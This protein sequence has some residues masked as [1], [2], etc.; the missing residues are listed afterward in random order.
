VYP[1]PAEWPNANLNTAVFDHDGLHWF[2]GQSGVVGV[3]DPE[4]GEAEVFASPGGRGPYGITV[5]PDNVV[6]YASLAGNHI[7]RVD[8]PGS[9]TVIEPPTRIRVRA[10]CGPTRLGPCG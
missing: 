6:Y 2:T 10:G 7:A 8:G 1:L 3:L 9:V 5:T 4:T